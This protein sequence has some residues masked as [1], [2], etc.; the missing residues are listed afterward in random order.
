MNLRMMMLACACSLALGLGPAAGQNSTTTYQQW[1]GNDASSQEVDA[2]VQKLEKL[3]DQA[4]RDRAADP[5]FLTD[6]RNVLSGYTNPW[7]DRL[8]S[9]DFHDGNYT[10]SP[11]W[12]VSSG[13]FKVDAKGNNTGLRSTI[14]APGTSA[15]QTTGNTA[16]DILGTLLNKQNQNAQQSTSDAPYA[17]IATSVTI[18]NAFALRL[19]FVSA[20]KRGR[21]D[22]GPYQGPQGATA[23]RV[24]YLPGQMTDSLKLIRITSKGAVA[25][26][27]YKGPLNLEDGRRHVIEWKRDRGGAMTVSLDGNSMISATDRMIPK[28]FDGFMLINSGGTYWVRS[29]TIDGS[30]S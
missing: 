2:L 3:I 28:S 29:I 1:P 26:G 17:A 18:S 27:T 15:T 12:T 4:E 6:L 21:I 8:L 19:E 10:V 11:T 16:V 24:A 20:E 30:K 7:Q 25:I 23:Y 22:F 14:L 9:D 5:A 13:A